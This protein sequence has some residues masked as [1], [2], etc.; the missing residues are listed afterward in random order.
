MEIRKMS[1]FNTSGM[2]KT[3]CPGCDQKFINGNKLNRHKRTCPELNDEDD[4]EPRSL[5]EFTNGGS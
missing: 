3:S 1:Q 4:S 2:S 5:S